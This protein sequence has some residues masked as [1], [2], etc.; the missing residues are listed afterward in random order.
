[1][2]VHGLMHGG[3]RAA[4]RVRKDIGEG[5]PCMLGMSTAS[6]QD[7]GQTEEDVHWGY[8]EA[9]KHVTNLLY[10]QGLKCRQADISRNSSICTT[11]IPDL[12]KVISPSSRKAFNVCVTVCLLSPV[13]KA[14]S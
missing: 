9:M 12:S 13:K 7:E 3:T 4:M 1:M 11:C 5:Y 14:I 6:Q 8:D 10:G 2:P